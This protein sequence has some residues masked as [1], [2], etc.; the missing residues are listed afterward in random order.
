MAKTESTTKKD[1]NFA[2]LLNNGQ[3]IYVR[4]TQKGIIVLTVY[5]NGSPRSIRIPKHRHPVLL[6]MKASPQALSESVHL[7][8]AI[9]KGYLQLV[10]PDEARTELSNPNILKK[11]MDAE[12]AMGSTNPEVTRHRDNRRSAEVLNE[13]K[14]GD[15]DPHEEILFDGAV[16]EGDPA[17]T[18]A[19]N[20]HPR[21][22]IICSLLAE[23]DSGKDPKEAREE[24]RN[25]EDELE[26]SDLEYVVENTKAGIV[27]EWAQS[28]LALRRG[29]NT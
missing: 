3:E 28:E 6:S 19:A 15:I 11:V 4:N 10:D 22:S 25:I 26:I 7:R 17:E 8:E 20:V 9:Y 13:R 14:P 12:K 5:Q 23:K 27:R 18:E 24:L 1:P 21:V 16:D 2:D 29:T